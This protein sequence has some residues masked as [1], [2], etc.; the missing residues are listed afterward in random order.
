MTKIEEEVRDVVR[1]SPAPDA[2][3]AWETVTTRGRR[4]V[5]RRRLARATVALGVVG[6]IV[7]GIVYVTGSGDTTSR[8]IVANPGPDQATTAPADASVIPPGQYRY[9]KV[10]GVWTATTVESPTTTYTALVPRTYEFWTGADDSGRI[11]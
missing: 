9:V 10:T 2:V 5:R 1:E 4:I 7:L 8:S 3:P 11:R 6:A